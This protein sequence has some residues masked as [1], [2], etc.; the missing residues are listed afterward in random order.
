MM[1]KGSIVK[2]YRAV[3][4]MRDAIENYRLDHPQKTIAEV[5][6]YFGRSKTTSFDPINERETDKEKIILQKIGKIILW[7]L[8]G[9]LSLFVIFC[10]IMYLLQQI[11][12]PTYIK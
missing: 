3:A 5:M 7:T 12:I 11:A 2:R 8:L 4:M 6:A 1:T 9:L 10:L